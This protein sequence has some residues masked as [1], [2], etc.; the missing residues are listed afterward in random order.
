MLCG[1]ESDMSFDFQD[2]EE[3]AAKILKFSGDEHSELN[4]NCRPTGPVY[5]RSVHYY[6]SNT[7]NKTY[8][9][10]KNLLVITF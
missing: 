9:T 6:C 4:Q 7:V 5:D 8:N 10:I 1:D 3:N 2:E